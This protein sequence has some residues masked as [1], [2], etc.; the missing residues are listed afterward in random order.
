VADEVAVMYLGVIV[1]RGP[2]ETLIDSPKHPYTQGLLAAIPRL[3]NL[4]RRLTPVG[5]DIPGPRERPTGCPFHPR[6]AHFTVSVCDA[7][8]PERT[9]MAPGHFVRCFLYQK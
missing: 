4:K 9:A 1:E 3:D 5:G 6:C 2:T 8:I 7:A